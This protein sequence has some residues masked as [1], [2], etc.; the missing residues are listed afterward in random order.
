MVSIAIE[1]GQGYPQVS[2]NEFIY[3]DFIFMQLLN[4]LKQCLRCY[5]F[6]QLCYKMLSSS[7]SK[8]IAYYTGQ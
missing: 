1:P 3:Y 8:K 7:H 2:I 4:S 5:M 6:L